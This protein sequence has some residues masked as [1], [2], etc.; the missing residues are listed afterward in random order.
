M[1]VVL[2]G[3]VACGEHGNNGITE[4]IVPVTRR[5]GMITPAVSDRKSDVLVRCFFGVKM[6]VTGIICFSEQSTFKDIEFK[7]GLKVR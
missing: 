2:T 1:V 3:D 4:I 7:L 5:P 6:V